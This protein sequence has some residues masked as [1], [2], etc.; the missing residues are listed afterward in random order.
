[1]KVII[2]ISIVL[3]LLVIVYAVLYQMCK[4]YKRNKTNLDKFQNIHQEQ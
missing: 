2:V 3:V 1:M 4:N